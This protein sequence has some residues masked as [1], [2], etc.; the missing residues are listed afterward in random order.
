MESWPRCI[1][2][3]HGVTQVPPCANRMVALD[4][5]ELNETSWWTPCMTVAQ[6]PSA[7]P[8][9]I[10]AQA[11]ISLFMF[12]SPRRRC[13]DDNKVSALARPSKYKTLPPTELQASS[14]NRCGGVAHNH[15]PVPRPGACFGTAGTGAL[16]AQ[17]FPQTNGLIWS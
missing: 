17:L 7:G 12:L 13:V 2:I 8:D 3:W 15:G 11:R 6:P 4:G 16:A 14:R 9:A 1:S 5:S 10:M